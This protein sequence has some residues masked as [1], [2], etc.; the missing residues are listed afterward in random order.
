MSA[1]VRCENGH[2]YNPDEKECPFCRKRREETERMRKTLPTYSN[3]WQGGD[4][5]SD[6]KTMAAPVEGQVNLGG[7]LGRGP[8][9]MAGISAG[10]EGPTIGIYSKSAGNAYVT[11]WL[12]GV[13]GP[14]RGRDYR[15]MHGKNMVGH[16]YNADITI[17][18]GEGISEIGHCTVVYDGKGNQFYLVPGNGSLTY[19]NGSLLGEPKELSLG[20]RIKLGNCEFEFVPFCREGHVWE[21]EEP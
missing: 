9:G 6:G 16:S 13:K 7:G 18:E 1:L 4:E 19:L 20:D 14:V 5:D 15:I 12:V 2:Y 17:N 11:G 21:E 10:E 3:V 8:S